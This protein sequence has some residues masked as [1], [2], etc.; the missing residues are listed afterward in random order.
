MNSPLNTPSNNETIKKTTCA[1]CGVGCGVEAKVD[2]KT[3]SIEVIGCGDHPANKGRLCSKGSALDQT[4]DLPKDGEFGHRLLSPFID[5]KKA[6]WDDALDKVANG[7]KDIIEKHGKDS[8]AFYV[9]GQLLTEDYYVAN[10]LMKGFIGSANIDTNS[11]LCMSSSVSGH[12]RA[13]GTD[14]VPG[15]YEDFENADLITLVGSNTAWCHPV[16]FQRIKAYKEANPKVK[17]VVIDPRRTQTCDIAD[18]HLPLKPGTDVNLFNGL[19]NY[20]AD[21]KKL[22]QSFIE[23]HCENF[24]EALNTAKQTGSLSDIAKQLNIEESLLSEFYS[25]F[26]NTEKAVTLYSQGVN[27][28]SAGTDKVNSILNCHL[29]T[30]R[31]GKTGM[32]PFSM[33]GQPNAMGGREVGGMANTLAAH[34]D[35]YDD[36]I[37][38]VNRF[39]STDNLT[40]DAPT[41]FGL[42][43]VNLFNAIDSGKVKA[44]WVM[45]TNPVVSL[46]NADL[47]K[48]ALDKCELVVVSDCIADT[49][50]GRH[51]NVLLPATGWSEKDGTV[52]N[53][54]RRISRQRSLLS[55]AGESKHDWWIITEVAKRMGFAEAFPYESQ[56]DIFREHAELSGFEN[57]F[58][59]NEIGRLRD[60]DISAW[61]NIS[62]AEYDDLAPTQWPVNAE[63]PN[64]RQRFFA[65]GLFYTPNRKAQFIATEPRAPKNAPN[66]EFPFVLNSGRIRDQWHTMTRTSL[67]ARLNQHIAEP[68]V[69]IHPD[70]A[71]AQGVKDQQIVQVESRWGKMLGR[72]NVTSEQQTGSLFAPMH[73][74]GILSKAGRVNP[75]VNPEIDPVSMQPESKHTPVSIKAF[76]AKW[77]GFVLTR[78]S[79]QWPQVNGHTLDYVVQIG[80]EQYTRYEL[81]HSQSLT[82]SDLDPETQIRQWLNVG[83]NQQVMTYADSGS[84]I[85]RLALLSAEG[86]LEAIAFLSPNEDLPDRTWLSS[87]FAEEVVNE[88]SRAALLSGYAPAGED[89]GRIVCACFSVGENT[90]KQAIA[91]HGLT[92]AADIGKHLKAGTNC[93]SCVPEIKEILGSFDA[94]A[95]KAKVAAL[96]SEA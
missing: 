9:S 56:V 93:G 63:H 52:T 57:H 7:F 38:R 27:Q 11:R 5:G 39:W 49:D 47:V 37:D 92:S 13:F 40:A 70:D 69:E 83:E 10:K 60:F 8:V 41:G 89:M 61:A 64:G 1:Y 74:T 46:P 85:Y 42:T 15:C 50:T 73:W 2:E 16:L 4:V 67:A 54:E 34:M 80:G 17:L 45:A 55:P 18:L 78:N 33:T 12:K 90:I 65:D 68:F 31:I 30:G 76:E 35:F 94:D 79:I 29:A 3:R 91:E 77:H 20:L 71:K 95:Y 66:A 87:L 25:L 82:N 62:D 59:K 48:Q 21:H 6:N 19:L 14:T 58:P 81:A 51:A 36:N 32:G 23:S 86:R 84:N 28:S 44:I 26:A 53:S 88:R 72:L 75:V 96:A 22:D 24:E 43:A